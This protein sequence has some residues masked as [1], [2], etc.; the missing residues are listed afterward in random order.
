[1]KNIKKIITG[2]AIVAFTTTTIFAYDLTE[3]EKSK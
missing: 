2:I 1:M 3:K